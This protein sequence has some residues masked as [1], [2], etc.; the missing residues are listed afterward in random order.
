VRIDVTSREHEFE[1][2]A[3]AEDNKSDKM[4]TRYRASG[5]SL[6]FSLGR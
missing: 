5:G 4:S 1:L 6:K 2:F 3:S